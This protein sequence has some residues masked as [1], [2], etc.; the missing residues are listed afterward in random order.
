MKKLLLSLILAI[1]GY[2]I[3]AQAPVISIPPTNGLVCVGN[4]V[5]INATYSGNATT[6]LWEESSDGAASWH[7]IIPNSTYSIFTNGPFAPGISMTSLYIKSVP[8]SMNRYLYRVTLSNASGSSGASPYSVLIVNQ[9]P[10]SQVSFLNPQLNVCL[11]QTLPYV[12]TGINVAEDSIYW[13]YSGAISSAFAGS[14]FADTTILVNFNSTGTATVSAFMFNGCG[15]VDLTTN[16]L[17]ITVN[18]LQNTPAAS[19]G[20]GPV[21]TNYPV[22]SGATTSFSDATCNP[23]SVINPSGSHPLSGNVQSC[24]TVDATVQSFGGIP[25]VPR[26]YSLTSSLTDP[27]TST[28]TVTL[29]FTQGDFDAYNA[30]RGS[31]PALPMNSS[32]AAGIANLHITQFHGTGTTPDTYV[33]GSGDIDPADNN[34]V[35][36]AAASRWEVTFDI[37]GFSGFFVSGSSIIP[38]P[39]T[40]GEFSGK[41]TKAGNQLHWT[42]TMEENTAYF[43]V[44]RKGDDSVFADLA[45]VPAAGNSNQLLQ[46]DY[47]DASAAGA[48]SYRLKMVDIDGK[49]TY[50]RIVALGSA[51]DALTIRVLPNPAHQPLS[52]TVGSPEVAGAVLTV[53][54]MSGKKILEKHVS[55]QKGNNSLDP[56]FLATLPQGMYLIGVAT[57]KQQQTIKFVRD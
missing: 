23:V 50:S 25:Y 54:D 7:A 12:L 48:Y 37:T 43:E 39:L 20:G 36:N 35:W 29:Y 11:G 56:G 38:L 22:F 26:H 28:A 6:T 24:V 16:P 57:D 17:H 46:Y 14:A 4:N 45:K 18:P 31:N 5:F 8:V 30:A 2:T 19:P 42:T 33:G 49:F 32:D 15:S 47:L 41:A 40:M 1:I 13:N 51:I 9:A 55:L 34:I 10:P 44:Q 3:Y 27:T 21:C 53:S 52:L